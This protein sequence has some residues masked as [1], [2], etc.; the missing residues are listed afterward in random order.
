MS[1][2]YGV[3]AKFA[4]VVLSNRQININVH[5]IKRLA[6]ESIERNKQWKIQYRDWVGIIFNPD[7]FLQGAIFGIF[8]HDFYDVKLQ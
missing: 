4:C 3:G 8:A 7:Q 6:F 1:F 2:S 5:Y